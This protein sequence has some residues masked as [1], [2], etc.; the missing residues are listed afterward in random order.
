M[1][2]LKVSDQFANRILEAL[3]PEDRLIDEATMAITIESDAQLD[4]LDV[5]IF[6]TLYADPERGWAD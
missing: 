4:A 1:R 3:E 5:A 6:E 2:L